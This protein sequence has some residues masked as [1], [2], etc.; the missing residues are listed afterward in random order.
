MD[1]PV[2]NA[3]TQFGTLRRVVVGRADASS[4]HLPEEPAGH[5]EIN[6]PY[7][8]E[9]LPWPGGT[10]KHAQT[11]ALA[12]AQLDNF[13][14]VLEAETVRVSTR[15]E[16]DTELRR[17]VEKRRTETTQS[18]SQDARVVHK[19]AA[20]T[21]R[22]SP[23]DWT[24]PVA[25]PSWTSA[26]QYCGTCPR[27]TMIT[28]GNTILEATMSK[29]SRY[30]EHLSCRSICLDLWR[31]DPR[32]VQ[33]WAA[34][35]PSMADS[36]YDL[37]FWKLSSQERYRLMHEYRYC[38]NETE[39]V[40]DAADITRVGRDIF[41]Q[42]S[43]TTND[44]GIQWIQCHF[45]HLRVHPVHFP[46]DLYPSHI[47]CNF[48]PLRPPVGGSDGLVLVN[49][50]RPLLKEES[51]LWRQNGWKMLNAPMP[52]QLDRPAFSQSSYWLSMN[53]LSLSQSVVVIEENE[54]PLF[55]LLSEHG[56]ECVTVGMRHMYE[57]GGGIHCCTWDVQRDDA[58][59]DYFPE[60]A[61]E[62]AGTDVLDLSASNDGFVV[63]PV[64]FLHIGS[65]RNRI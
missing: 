26:S 59:V 20:A 12:S 62:R 21:L 1:L 55:Q 8:A 36:M 10:R 16:V 51:N 38:V 49:P 22:P 54:V 44:L 56:F 42:R 33:L 5:S 29:R 30:F 23:M 27:D 14:A 46:Y 32:R 25:G 34:P 2:V 47:D 58:C 37:D 57:F 60:A 40:F 7:L 17:E 28:L 53:L 13:V 64:S 18:G 52:A 19:P 61:E 65:Y 3:W 15:R 43:M 45:P 35:K 39:P 24:K 31:S 50:E 9:R 4:C 41:V 11:V 48:V 6:D 63:N